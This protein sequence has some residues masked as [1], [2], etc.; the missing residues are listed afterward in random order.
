M[1]EQQKPLH[2]LM[3]EARIHAGD[4][5][6]NG[7]RAQSAYAAELYAIADWLDQRLPTDQ[8]L[9]SAMDLLRDEARL[10][11]KNPAESEI[12]PT[13]GTLVPSDEQPNDPLRTMDARAWAAEFMKI[14]GGAADEATMLAWFANAMMCG[15][16]HHYWQSDEY[17]REIAKCL[18]GNT[19]ATPPQPPGA[20]TPPDD[21]IEEWQLDYKPACHGYFGPYIA[22]KTADWSHTQAMQ[23][24]AELAGLLMELRHELYEAYHE[25]GPDMCGCSELIDRAEAAALRLKGGGSDG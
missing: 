10:A 16:D 14:T 9:D 3:R 8:T 19:M 1:T 18:G 21:L 23:Q 15:W 2:L 22:K 20:P 12:N 25:Y 6:V 4:Q 5:L 13:P 11:M 24:R 7:W 17:K